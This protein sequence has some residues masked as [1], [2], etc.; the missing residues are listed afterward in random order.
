MHD[1]PIVEVEFNTHVL[2]CRLR[3]LNQALGKARVRAAKVLSA[4]N[5]I[6]DISKADTGRGDCPLGFL[7]GS[8][9][10]LDHME[11]QIGIL[12]DCLYGILELIGTEIIEETE[13]S[14]PRVA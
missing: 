9:Y 3:E 8:K 12:S 13:E 10:H 7:P 11:G 4:M 14:A 5:G 2:Q 1:E 6:N